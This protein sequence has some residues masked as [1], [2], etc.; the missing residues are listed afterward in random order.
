MITLNNLETFSKRVIQKTAEATGDLI[1]NKIANRITK[2][3][4]ISLQN[5][6]EAIK[7]TLHYKKI[8]LHYRETP[9]ERYMS[10][11]ERQKIID[12]LRLI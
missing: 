6:S 3:P 7:I 12:D 10:P 4:R 11:E 2:V 9:K 8:Q 1:G 5:N